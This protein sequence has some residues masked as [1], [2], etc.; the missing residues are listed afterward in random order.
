MRI[1]AHHHFWN[2]SAKEYGW[3]G[4]TKT[5]IRRDFMAKDLKRAIDAAGIDGVVSVQ[6]RETLEETDF[7]L[8]YAAQNDFI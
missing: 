8:D 3:I 6:A 4:D 1:D 7:L 2:Y 5:R